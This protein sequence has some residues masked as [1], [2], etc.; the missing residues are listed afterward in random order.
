MIKTFTELHANAEFGGVELYRSVFDVEVVLQ[1]T[2]L[3]EFFKN[4][5]RTH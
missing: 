4:Q 5:H 3:A 1:H 2:R